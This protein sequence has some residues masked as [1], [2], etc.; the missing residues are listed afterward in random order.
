MVKTAF[1]V[2]GGL[3]RHLV[4]VDEPT[5]EARLAC[6]QA[7]ADYRASDDR[8][9]ACGCFVRIKAA[10]TVTDCPR[11]KWGSIEPLPPQQQEA[12]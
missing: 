1:G 12:T 2:I 4:L 9:L 10:I 11:G 8:C 6:C 5:R 7:C 3:A